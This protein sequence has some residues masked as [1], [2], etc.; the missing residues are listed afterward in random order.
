MGIDTVLQEYFI[1]RQPSCP[2]SSGTYYRPQ[3]VGGLEVKQK[4]NAWVALAI[5]SFA[6]SVLFT[7]RDQDRMAEY[8][9][10][11]RIARTDTNKEKSPR[12]E[13]QLMTTSIIGCGSAQPD[14]SMTDG[15][16]RSWLYSVFIGVAYADAPIIPE[17]GA[18]AALPDS[19]EAYPK[20][21]NISDFHQHKPD[22]KQ[23]RVVVAALPRRE[24]ID[25]VSEVS[26][27][28]AAKIVILP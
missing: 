1:F 10:R 11:P 22:L 28:I 21:S 5:C 8:N 20:P 18:Y 16:P 27:D 7:F 4:L 2:R 17:N 24:K 15:R 6:D 25:K 9:R 12:T 3:M 13:K 19:Q 14:L 23:I 26:I